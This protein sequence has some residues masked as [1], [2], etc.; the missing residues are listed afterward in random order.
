M[1]NFG[2]AGVEYPIEF[3]YGEKLAP[4]LGFTYDPFSDGRTKI[5]GSWGKYF[6]VMKYE[7][8]RGSFGGDKWVDYWFTWDNPD[9]GVN[10]APSCRTGSNTIAER[11]TCPGGTLHRGVRPAPQRRGGSRPVSSSRT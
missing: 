6:D 2:S 11:P 10:N 1:P 7:M 3:G 5:Y 8:P 4:R 9:V